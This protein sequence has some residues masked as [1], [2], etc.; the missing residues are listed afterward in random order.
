MNRARIAL[1]PAFILARRPY[2]DTSLLIEA[3]TRNH[4]RIGLVARGVRGPR[5]SRSALLQPLTPLLLSWI[6]GGE[7]GTLTTVE[8]DGPALPLKGEG[9]FCAWYVNELLLNLLQRHD[10]HPGLYQDYAATLAAL[11][12][13]PPEPLL[14]GFEMRLLGEIGYGLNLDQEFD[15]AAEYIYDWENGPRLAPAGAHTLS[16]SCLVSLRDSRLSN[17]ADLSAARRLLREAIRRQ[18]NGRELQTPRLLRELRRQQIEEPS[19]NA[20]DQD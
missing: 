1:E 10:P 16:G 12:S 19:G 11:S 2:R 14:R 20:P 17:P 5:S 7:L 4:G 9:I 13:L 8:G 3:Y 18:L 6:E 15:P